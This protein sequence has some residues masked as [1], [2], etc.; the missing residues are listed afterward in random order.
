MAILDRNGDQRLTPKRLGQSPGFGLG[1]PHQGR[2]NAESL[3]HAKIQCPLRRIQ[4]VAPTVWIAR[5]VRLAHSTDQRSQAPTIRQR[6]RIEQKHQIATGHI[7]RRQTLRCNLDR[8]VAGHSGVA[9][10]PETA[11]VQHM[12]L[13][14]AG[15]PLREF[16][17]QALTDP[18]SCLK[19]DGM[20]LPVVETYRLDAAIAVQRPCQTGC[21]VLAAGKEQERAVVH[22]LH[23]GVERNSGKSGKA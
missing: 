17:D 8:A 20:A 3:F 13:A 5:E 21:G 14:Q 10:P 18:L 1:Q 2:L 22:R 12:V 11:D 7:G 9:D 4:G 23:M 19:L 15:L 16:R 6:G